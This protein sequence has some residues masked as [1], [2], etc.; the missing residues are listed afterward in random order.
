LQL[1]ANVKLFAAMTA[2]LA[3]ILEIQTFLSFQRVLF[4]LNMVLVPSH[5][6]LQVCGTCGVDELSE[7]F[8][9]VLVIFLRPSL[10]ILQQFIELLQT[11]V[12]LPCLFVLYKLDNFFAGKIDVLY[13]IH[14]LTFEDS[15]FF[16]FAGIFQLLYDVVES[17]RGSLMRKKFV[18]FLLQFF[19]HFGNILDLSVLEIVFYYFF[20][21]ILKS[22]CLLFLAFLH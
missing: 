8:V 7:G 13:R 4:L 1:V 11:F 5:L 2:Y 9:D 16:R 12:F 10:A 22:I 14:L 3:Y 21:L 20:E 17:H 6:Y 15:A 19:V 18:V